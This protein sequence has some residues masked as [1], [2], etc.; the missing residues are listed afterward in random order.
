MRWSR[1]G[2]ERPGTFEDEALDEIDPARA[3]LDDLSDDGGVAVALRPEA[4]HQLTGRIGEIRLLTGISTSHGGNSSCCAA[5]SNGQEA[6][7]PA[8]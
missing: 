8:G 4:P 7:P 2:N 6:R 3:P 1:P 5:D